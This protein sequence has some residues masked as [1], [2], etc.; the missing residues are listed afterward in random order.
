MS[1][2]KF[3]IDT[4]IGEAI[5]KPSKGGRPLYERIPED[6]SEF[7]SRIYSSP[8]NIRAIVIGE[9]STV[10]R[11]W[12]KPTG[13]KDII[14]HGKLGVEEDGEKYTLRDILYKRIKYNSDMNEYYQLKGHGSDV[15][16]PKQVSI[17]GYG[18]GCLLRP[19]VCNNIE[20]IVFSDAMLIA[21]N[22]YN[23]RNIQAMLINN[24][25]GKA[26]DVSRGMVLQHIVGMALNVQ[27][28]QL[29]NRFPLLKKIVYISDMRG[30]N[31]LDPLVSNK[32]NRE[33][34][35]GIARRL[36]VT[37]GY[38]DLQPISDELDVREGIYVFDSKLRGLKIKSIS[39]DTKDSVGETVVERE[40]AEKDKAEEPVEKN[41][42]IKI[43]ERAIL[44]S[45]KK[46]D[47][48]TEAIAR[49][50]FA[51]YGIVEQYGKVRAQEIVDSFDSEFI[52]QHI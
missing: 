31:N 33:Q 9:T 47:N 38:V 23:Q 14:M 4:I 42:N 25:D 27:V 22:L 32:F 7:T 36:N 6:G 35:T 21:D 41:K 28:S 2:I 17:T 11:A 8:T 51:Y 24:A 10:T 44:N 40:D 3:N 37:C 13:C 34:F 45:V 50:R 49:V 16:K 1:S 52:K 46:A 12:V 5:H 19:W 30:L 43:I 48:D 18:L 29:R 15:E 39:D 26:T 20:T